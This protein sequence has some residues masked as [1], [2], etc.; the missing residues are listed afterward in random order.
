MDEIRVGGYFGRKKILDF[1]RLSNGWYVLKTENRKSARDFKVRV[2]YSLKP[3]RWLT[4]N[5]HTLQLTFTVS[6]AQIRRRPC[7]FLLQ[8]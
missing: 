4:L 2:I 5:T 1:V 3:L 7:A 8:S 6:S